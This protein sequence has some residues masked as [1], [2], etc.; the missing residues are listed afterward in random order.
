MSDSLYL[1]DLP[2]FTQ[3]I[4]L[5][6]LQRICDREAGLRLSKAAAVSSLIN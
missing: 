3:G 2:S 5:S 6:P 1:T 4:R